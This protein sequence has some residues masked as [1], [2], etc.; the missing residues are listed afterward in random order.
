M[1]I[2]KTMKLPCWVI[3]IL[4]KR[5]HEN[6]NGQYERVEQY[7]LSKPRITVLRE[8]FLEIIL[9]LICYYGD[10]FALS[11]ERLS[12]IAELIHTE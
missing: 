4:S 1:D 2:E 8:K 12:E 5:V 7:Y 3:D 9:K 6:C 10:P 11:A